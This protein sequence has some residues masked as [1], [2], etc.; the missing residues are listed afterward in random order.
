MASLFQGEPQVATSYAQ[1]TS[2]TPRWMQDAIYNLIQTSTNIANRPY[3]AY[4]GERVAGFAPQQLQAYDLVNK[5][6]GAYQPEM[7]YASTGMKDFSGRGTADQLQAGQ[8]PY[9]RQDLVGSNLNAASNCMA[10]PPGWTWLRRPSLI[11]SALGLKIFWDQPSRIWA[12]PHP[13]TSWEPRSLIW[14]KRRLKI[15]QER[16]NLISTKQRLKIL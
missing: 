15:L 7:N 2:E 6:V 1:N 10:K 16:L 9:L 11:F 14:A 3:E 8:A 12:K 5:N 4:K 13:K